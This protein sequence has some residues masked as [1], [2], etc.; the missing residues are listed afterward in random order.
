[1]HS[2]KDKFDEVCLRVRDGRRLES[3][4]SAPIYYLVF[5]VKQILEVKRQTKAWIAKLE[6]LGW[7]VV[8]F[9]FAET[10]ESIFKNHKLRGSWVV[11]EKMLLSKSQ[12]GVSGVAMSQ[13]NTTLAKALTEGPELLTLIRQ[14]MTEASSHSNG[15]L[16]F[17]E[18]EAIHP[19]LRINSIEAKIQ[20]EVRSPV[21]VLYPGKREGKTSLKFLEFYPAD[22]NYRSEHVG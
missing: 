2:L 7:K 14:K 3:T 12:G 5:P 8:T 6:N 11:G 10:L 4:G 9:S 19:Y 18:L 13:I 1:M 15:L 21:I 16:L 22:P 17:T 20:D